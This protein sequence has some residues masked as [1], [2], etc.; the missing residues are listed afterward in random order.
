MGGGG[1]LP[2]ITWAKKAP[3]PKHVTLRPT[4]ERKSIMGKVPWRCWL[5]TRP[6]LENSR[7]FCGA[8][9]RTLRM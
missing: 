1:P 8:Y 9:L 5:R 3:K 2:Y 4:R 7:S 6:V